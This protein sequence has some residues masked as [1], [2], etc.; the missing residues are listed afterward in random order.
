MARG[1]VSAA[2]MT[3]SEVPRLRVLVAVR[4]RYVSNLFNPGIEIRRDS[5][6]CFLRFER[7]IDLPAIQGVTLKQSEQKISG[8]LF[9]GLVNGWR[10]THLRWHP[11][12]ADGSEKPAGQ[13]PTGSESRP[14]RRWARL[15]SEKLVSQSPQIKIKSNGALTG[16]GLVSS[17]HDDVLVS[18]P[19]K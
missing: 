3:I 16:S 7:P 13:G 5:V 15:N 14:R 10:S 18:F 19:C 9:R 11:S 17:R 12:S 6:F 8:V 1:E 4:K 2:R